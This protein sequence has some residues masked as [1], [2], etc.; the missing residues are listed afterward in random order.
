MSSPFSWV[1]SSKN[2]HKKLITNMAEKESFIYTNLENIENKK[3]KLRSIQASQRGITET[4]KL[5]LGSFSI[6]VI[7]S[8]TIRSQRDYYCLLQQLRVYFCKSGASYLRSGEK[9][10]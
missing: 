5:Q 7:I 10:S 4:S 6:W 1:E 9:D 8:C 2:I 3:K